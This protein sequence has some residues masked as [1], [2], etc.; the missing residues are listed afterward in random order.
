L[1]SASSAGRRPEH[2]ADLRR[3]FQRAHGSFELRAAL[4]DLAVRAR[5]GHGDRRP[6]SKHDRRLLVGALKLAVLLVGQEEVTPRLVI[7]QDRDVDRPAA[8]PTA[9]VVELAVGRRRLA[10]FDQYAKPSGVPSEAPLV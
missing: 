8:R 2:A 10:G 4:I 9:V 1:N 6:P 5:V 3:C 7:D